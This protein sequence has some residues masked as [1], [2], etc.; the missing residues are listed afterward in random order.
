[1]PCDSSALAVRGATFRD[2]RVAYLAIWLAKVG[3]GTGL[4]TL[5]LGW[6]WRPGSKN[7]LWRPSLSMVSGSGTVGLP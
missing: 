3:K 4:L 1:M 5:L 2:L 6:S 7:R